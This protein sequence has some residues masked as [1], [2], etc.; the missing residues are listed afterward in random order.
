MRKYALALLLAAM[1]NAAFSQFCPTCIQDGS[2]P[3]NAQMNI[4]TAT[5]RGTLTASTITVTN[6]NMSTATAAVFVG[7]GTYLTNLN[8]SQLKSGTV[9]TSAVSGNY[10]GVTGVG[11]IS[12][13]TWAATILAPQYGGTG[14]NWSTIN[15]GA[16]PFFSNV[17]ALGTVASPAFLG[18]LESTGTGGT[19]VWVSSPAIQGYLFSDVPIASLIGTSIPASIKVSSGSLSYVNAVS[20]YGNI[21]GGAAFLTSTMSLTN[22]SSGTL[23]TSIVASSIT[24][25]GIW[26]GTYGDASH[27]LQVK[28]GTDGR[29]STV[30]A[31]NISLPLSGLQS[32][33]L[34]G[35]VTI[36][37][38]GVNGGTLGST[39][40]A[41]SVAATGVTAG[42]YGGPTL[43]AQIVVGADGRVTSAAQY[44][45][46][47]SSAN[48]AFNDVDNHW[49]Y[50]Q[51]SASSWT[52]RAAIQTT[53]S[54]TASAFFGDASHLTGT[55]SLPT[56]AGALQN[57]PLASS[58]LPSTVAYTN[59]A[60]TFTAAQTVSGTSVTASAFFGDGSHLTGVPQT[61]VPA[62]GITG[63]PVA[64]SIL[65]STV[66][67]TNAANTFTA[68]LTVSGTS[69][70]AS[71][72]FGNG[73]ALT[74]LTLPATVLY[75]NVASTRTAALYLSA[76]SMTMTGPN[77]YI[78]SGS[79]IIG[80]SFYGDGS[81][82]TNVTSSVAVNAGMVVNGP[83]A[84]SILPST[85][86][87]TSVIETFTAAQYMSNSSMTLT[88]SSG[89]VTSGSSINASAFFGDASHLSRVADA[90][91]ALPS[92]VLPS[93][94][95]YT[96]NANTF[97]AAQT[98]NS[99]ATASA[100]FGDGSHLTGLS[101]IAATAITAGTFGSGVLLPPANV[102]PGALGTGVTIGAAQVTAG[103]FIAGVNIPA[104]NVL[105]GVL[106]VTSLSQT[107][108][109]G[110]ITAASSV[111]ASA[112]FGNGSGL[113]GVTGAA[114]TSVPAGGITGS[115]VNSSILPSTVAYTSLANTFTM[116]QRVT[117]NNANEAGFYAVGSANPIIMV[118]ATSPAIQT[119][120]E[121]HNSASYGRIGTY[122]A[123]DI[124]F[125]A[126]NTTPDLAA[127]TTGGSFGIGTTSPAS[128]LDVRGI[129]A[130]GSA[131]TQ[132]TFTA[133]GA[134][135]LA[136]N[137]AMTG[138]S[139]VTASAFFGNASGLTGSG[140]GLTGVTALYLTATNGT[141]I[142]NGGPLPDAGQVLTAINGTT[143]NWA[144]PSC[145]AGV[146]V[147]GPVASSILPSTVAYTNRDNNW[148]AAQTFAS[149]ETNTSAG[150]GNFTYGLTVG[151]LT[152]T[153][154]AN[155][156]TASGNVGIGT[157]S[158]ATVLD[159]NGASQFGSGATKSTFTAAGNLSAVS[160]FSIVGGSSVTLTGTSNTQFRVNTD[161]TG[162]SPRFDMSLNGVI[163]ALFGVASVAGGLAPGS[164]AGSV[165]FR[166]ATQRIYFTADG[167][168]TS[169]MV[170]D[171]GG[172]TTWSSSMTA[173]GSIGT[174]GEL[175][176]GLVLSCTLGLT[177]TSTGAIT[178]CVA[179]DGS[180]KENIAPLDIDLSAVDALRPVTYDWKDK[181]RGSN[182]R[183]GFVAQD[184]QAVMPTAVTPAGRGLL[185][186][187]PNALIGLLVEEVKDLRKRMAEM[188]KR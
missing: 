115:P 134:L 174:T 105:S 183:A 92:G 113:T 41:S 125:T 26:A 65:P 88:G 77:G 27:A 123:H 187:D 136:A 53:S 164:A 188:E 80:S 47:V 126:N 124:H 158:P 173:K 176:Q 72:F 144:T 52:F 162:D 6:L 32:G 3:Q 81:H 18:V 10:Q 95:A 48:A 69:V 64:S 143:A 104:A 122:S 49:S 171:T 24:G 163:K 160:G 148:S 141:I 112:F 146:L 63:G 129:S 178:G 110:S 33:T 103:N 186:V 180:L 142:T 79:S 120:M 118:Q 94:V 100:F 132:S 30:T 74:A 116:Q 96:S 2:A 42:T 55:A 45:S 58:I 102:N 133:L 82:L 7:S 37:A 87:Y 75:T 25:T 14:A 151:T 12:S 175:D 11:T 169:H 71:A 51:T 156:A 91:A 139:S 138:T 35:S 39:V 168:S 153:S 59:A 131:G 161:G 78:V 181:A 56:N 135:T 111:T 4:G 38:A 16:L 108:G 8:A 159:V 20:V 17:G 68:A 36:A 184:V 114:A 154:G 13:G 119:F 177:T 70:T 5:I 19:P 44:A 150:G 101:A 149:S 86:A 182:T 34:P 57:G 31:L 40:V 28:Y 147:N 145:A 166:S 67:Y 73:S 179:S 90:I 54:A 89:Y 99:S 128:M 97:T 127:L 98:F 137:A 185:G 155:L 9:S 130:F 157:T 43:L 60:N 22:L 165:V 29:A 106:S 1:P 83:L 152:A 50:P 85:V 172:Q 46:A 167:G 121:A 61:T 15:P 23:P 21:S 84:S 107:G 170:M 117:D 76:S 62:G 109:A 66:A 140:A 93:T